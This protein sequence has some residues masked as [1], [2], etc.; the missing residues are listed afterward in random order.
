MLKY[1]LLNIINMLKLQLEP[2]SLGAQI[3]RM[4]GLYLLPGFINEP[5]SLILTL[6]LNS[7]ALPARR[8]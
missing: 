2:A 7:R 4:K 8:A 5:Q 3:F 6:C 1:L